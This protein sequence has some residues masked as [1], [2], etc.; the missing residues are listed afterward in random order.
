METLT[1]LGVYPL[2]I[3]II[4]MT[5]SLYYFFRCSQVMAPYGTY[6]YFE[7][8]DRGLEL[9][10]FA[11]IAFLFAGALFAVSMSCFYPNI[12]TQVSIQIYMVICVGIYTPTYIIAAGPPYRRNNFEEQEE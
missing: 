2:V 6:L 3:C 10:I 4:A 9:L 1:A 11:F 7:E 5:C 12:S 8:I